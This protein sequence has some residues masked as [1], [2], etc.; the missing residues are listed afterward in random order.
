[1]S[2]SSSELG[3]LPPYS[4]STSSADSNAAFPPKHRRPIRQL[5]DPDLE[6]VELR[7]L[8][9]VGRNKVTIARSEDLT[10]DNFDDRNGINHGATMEVYP[11]IWLDRRVAVKYLRKP[12]STVQS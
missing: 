6:N 8:R 10:L 1:M 12:W 2:S 5:G 4:G 7:F 9:V 11:G 3:A